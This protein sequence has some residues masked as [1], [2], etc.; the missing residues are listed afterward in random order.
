[1]ARALPVR[2]LFTTRARICLAIAVLVQRAN[3]KAGSRPGTDPLLNR[4]HKKRAPG[5]CP[6]L[7]L[8][9]TLRL[10]AVDADVVHGAVQAD[11]AAERQV[12][13][14]GITVTGCAIGTDAI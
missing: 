2:M 8:W 13:L 4:A 11:V 1:M 3:P 5:G 14:V 10:T 6:A 7:F 9:S 12:R